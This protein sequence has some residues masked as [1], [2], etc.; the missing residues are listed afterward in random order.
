MADPWIKIEYST[1]DK[2]E[3]LRIARA[4]GVDR[5]TVLGKLVRVWMWFDRVSVDGTV[6]GAELAD[7][8]AIAGITG[9]AAAM[10]DSGWLESPEDG[11]LRAVDFD[12]HNGSTAKKR[13]VTRDR[14]A[15]SRNAESVTCSYSLSFISFWD[16]WPSHHRKVNKP[17]CFEVWQRKQCDTF[18]EKIVT[19]VKALRQSQQWL[20]DAGKYVPAPLVYLSQERWDAAAAIE[21]QQYMPGMARP[22]SI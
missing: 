6:D 9:F 19:H 16:A 10:L 8:D 3:V 4:V 22:G 12:K 5:D 17:K 11:G 2:P 7:I 13:A 18:A 14:V 15:R 20:E 21:R 1:P